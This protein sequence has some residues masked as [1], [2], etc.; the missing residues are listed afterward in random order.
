MIDL[1][2]KLFIGKVFPMIV[3]IMSGKFLQC[4]SREIHHDIVNVFAKKNL[5]IL[6]SHS[7]MFHNLF[8]YFVAAYGEIDKTITKDIGSKKLICKISRMIPHEEN[9]NRN[10]EKINSIVCIPE[11]SPKRIR[12]DIV[13]RTKDNH[14]ISK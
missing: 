6:V 8:I 5:T 10:S 11:S 4:S 13:K 12:T 9:Q 1:C 14:L 7:A 3:N 2:F